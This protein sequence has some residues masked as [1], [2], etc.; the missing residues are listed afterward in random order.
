ME[1]ELKTSRG[2]P[3][4]FGTSRHA[5]GINF[6]LFSKH[7]THVSLCLFEKQQLEPLFE[8]PLDPK[9]NKTGD[10]WHVFIYEIPENLTYGYRLDGPYEPLEGLYYDKRNIVLDPYAK[11]VD[12]TYQWGQPYEP[13]IPHQIRGWVQPLVPF[14]WGDISSPR[15]PLNE[16]IIYEMHV[17][18]FT[19]DPSSGVKHPGSFLGLIEKIPYLKELGVNAVE[20]LPIFEFN[21]LEN[22]LFHPKTKEPHCQYWGYS[23]I[24]F[25]SPMNRFGVSDTITEFK[26]L[27]KELH[28]N[29]IEVILDVVY[30]HTAEGNQDG[31]IL[32]FK[33]IENPAYYILGPK[34][35]YYNFTGCGNTVNCN[36]PVALDLIRSSLRYW[37]TEMHVDGFRFDLASI[38]TRSQAGLPLENPPL[39]EALTL[40][41][42]LANVKFIAEAWDAVGLYQVGSFPGVGWSEWNGR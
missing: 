8:L 15:I 39:I 13:K 10:V 36:H 9:I 32:S 21:E 40:D 3:L 33:G 35:E 18:G 37:V 31:P 17:R 12:S 38:M 30:N 29:G 6:S 19:Q 41:P 24:N 16:L 5:N 23:T 26:T 28:A 20:L 2:F 25:F 7:A 4:P 42:I 1:P 14:H 22:K 11:R 27:V 34:G